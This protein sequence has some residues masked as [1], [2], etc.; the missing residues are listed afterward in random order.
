MRQIRIIK[1]NWCPQSV[2]T[3]RDL[4]FHFAAQSHAC[5]IAVRSP[6]R[7]EQA[8]PAPDRALHF[9]GGK[10]KQKDPT[11]EEYHL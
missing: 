2:N 1:V 11:P 3:E 8:Y 5:V 10:R 7:W 4:T 9:D 6:L